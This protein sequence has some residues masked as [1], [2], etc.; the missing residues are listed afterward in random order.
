[1]TYSEKLWNIHDSSISPDTLLNI[2][3]IRHNVFEWAIPEFE[4]YREWV[5]W[6][7]SKNPRYQN[8]KEVRDLLARQKKEI[9]NVFW[10]DNMLKSKV[11]WEA[12]HAA[13]D[14]NYAK[15]A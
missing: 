5:I 2:D 3:N 12:M 1:M 8:H 10:S 6:I 15:A 4:V 7:L 9:I 13:N 14:D 11:T